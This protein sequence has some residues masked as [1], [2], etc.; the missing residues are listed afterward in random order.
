[1]HIILSTMVVVWCVC[2]CVCVCVCACACA[3]VRVRV[4]VCVCV[5]VSFCLHYT[6]PFS[7]VVVLTKSQKKMKGV[8]IYGSVGQFSSIVKSIN[9]FRR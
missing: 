6:L 5:C 1:M 2:V 7:C 3:C 9:H 8:Y 4:R